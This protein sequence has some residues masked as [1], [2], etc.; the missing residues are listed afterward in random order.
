MILIDTGPL[1]SLFDPADKDHKSCR[2]V[3]STMRGTLYTSE[4]V[5]TESLYMLDQIS[6]GADRLKEFIL[7]DYLVIENLD[8]D[9]YERSFELME[10]YSNQPMDFADATLVVLS[11]KYRTDSIFTLD[12]SDF[13]AY[14]YL[15]GHKHYSFKL[16]GDNLLE[17]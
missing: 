16:L 5:L 1:V 17:Y 10:K 4:A 15:K 7:N 6:K 13:R 11:E 14:K 8:Y 12:F 9:L 3:L 2:K